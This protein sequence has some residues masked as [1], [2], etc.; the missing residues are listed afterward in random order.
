MS[1]MRISLVSVALL[2]LGLHAPAQAQQAPMGFFVT[3]VGSGKGGDLGGIAG[4]DQHCQ[5]LAQGAGGGSKAWRAYLSTQGPGAVNARDRIGSGPWAN[6]K[7]VVI[8][9]D[10][11]EADEALTLLQAKGVEG[12]VARD[13]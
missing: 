11:T 10:R 1:R 9:K 2:S 3:S 12:F 7:G 13:R 4:A 8:A 6:A 5:M